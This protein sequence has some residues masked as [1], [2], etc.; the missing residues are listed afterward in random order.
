[1]DRPAPTTIAMIFVGAIACA[2]VATATASREDPSS[3]L[4]VVVAVLWLVLAA[5]HWRHRSLRLLALL[6]LAL[7]L[8]S[9]LVPVAALWHRAPIVHLLLSGASWWPRTVAARVVVIAAYPASILGWPWVSPWVAA[10]L[11][12]A[13]LLAAIAEGRRRRGAALQVPA[14][15]ASVAIAAVAFAV[16]PLLAALGVGR[17][18]ALLVLSLYDVALGTIAVLLIAAAGPWRRSWAT[19]VAV[20][21]GPST[22]EELSGVLM[23]VRGPF[24]DLPLEA[25]AAATAASRL[26][27][28]LTARRAEL[29]ET[30]EQTQRSLRRLS[31]ANAR[32][33]QALRREL[34]DVAVVRLRA[35]IAH[36]EGRPDLDDVATSRALVQLRAAL[37]QLD[38]VG[39]GLLPPELGA[40]LGHALE[41]LASAS[42]VPVVFDG[43]GRAAIDAL[44]RSVQECVYFV[45]AEALANAAKHA[46]A[47]H[48]EARLT[49]SAQEAVLLVTDDGVGLGETEAGTGL[50]SMR[51]RALEV[52]GT[53]SITSG[54]R[55]GTAV[56]LTTPIHQGIV[57]TATSSGLAA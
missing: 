17:E 47:R 26:R 50:A 13:L 31:S 20:E 21:L 46:D 55:G 28:R 6:V 42:R 37:A 34:D 38:A 1:M 41:A 15:R 10:G 29:A 44:P 36:L 49:V 18:W 14:W 57:R 24:D 51:S 53:L 2:A 45:S 16:P 9:M 52:G 19:D 54:Q 30:I 43:A 5:L 7:W 4:H 27:E 39:E 35:V 33:R 48:V 3:A 56:R 23:A 8:T 11:A 12:A 25:A 40:G 32:E 22:R